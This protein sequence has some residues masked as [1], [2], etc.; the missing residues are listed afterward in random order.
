MTRSRPASIGR[1]ILCCALALPVPAETRAL[2]VRA[3]V[4][5]LPEQRFKPHMARRT[6][7]R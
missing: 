2:A 6:G 3:R 5:A 1:S 4:A 7:S